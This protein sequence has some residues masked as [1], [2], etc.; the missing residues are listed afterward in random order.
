MPKKKKEKKDERP[1]LKFNE[2]NSNEDINLAAHNFKKD[3]SIIIILFM[4]FHHGPYLKFHALD[5][6]NFIRQ[7]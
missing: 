4:L 2:K 1:F 7:K 5:S 3:S 6:F